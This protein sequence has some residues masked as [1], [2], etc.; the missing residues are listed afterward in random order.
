MAEASGLNP[1]KCEFESHLPNYGSM[2]KMVK[3][4][5]LGSVYFLGSSPSGVIRI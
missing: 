1:V 3:A 5:D 4:T 2:A